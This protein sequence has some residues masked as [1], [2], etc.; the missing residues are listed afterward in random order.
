MSEFKGSCHCGNVSYAVLGN[1]VSVVNC[2]C[3]LCR[4]LG[5]AAFA[6]YVVVRQAELSL[7]GKESLAS[8]AATDKATKHFCKICGTPIFNTNPVSYPSLVM[9]YL[10]TLASSPSITPKI[11]I[12]CESKLSWVDGIASI[13]GF[14][15]AIS[16][17]A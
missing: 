5:G 12:F 14:P 16:R 3:R 13:T 8:Y 15:Q 9:L 4:S 10:G 7:Q 2:H 1:I 6:S 11:N 17:G